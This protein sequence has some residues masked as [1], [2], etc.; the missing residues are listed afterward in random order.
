[1]PCAFDPSL[2]SLPRQR[3]FVQATIATN[4]TSGKNA[5]S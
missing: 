1:L 2:F 3:D 4:S 5:R